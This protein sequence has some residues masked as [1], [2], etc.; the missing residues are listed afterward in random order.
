MKLNENER[1]LVRALVDFEANLNKTK[2]YLKET[3]NIDV[4]FDEEN[5]VMRLTS[6]KNNAL[7]FIHAKKYVN[8]VFGNEVVTVVY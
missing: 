8:E 3:Y 4:T 6:E 5:T 2:T 7:D 1:T